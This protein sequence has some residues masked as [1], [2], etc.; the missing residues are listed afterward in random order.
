MFRPLFIIAIIIVTSN[1]Y[2]QTECNLSE[3]YPNI[4]KISKQIY[5]GE[6]YLNV[7]VISKLDTNTKFGKF[8]N[9]NYLYTDYLYKTFSDYSNYEKLKAINDSN[10][11][12]NVFLTDLLQ[13]T[14]FNAMMDK[15][16]A[17]ICNKPDF[18]PDT[19]TIN[20]LMN[21]AVKFF[22]LPKISEQ[23]NY[24]IQ[25]CVGINGIKNTLKKRRPQVEAFCFSSIFTHGNSGDFNIQKEFR[26]T[27]GKLYKLS[28]G[29]NL[30]ERLLRAQ[31]AV[32]MM[33]R[34]ND[35]LKNMLLSEYK[36]NM[37]YLPFVII[38]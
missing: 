27:V 20:E 19:I 31:G 18:I 6:E 23:G 38:D 15:F 25:I 7:F 1:L 9:E 29:N 37:N 35:V 3:L 32:Y 36:K 10:E 11:L 30:E 28:L 34:D 4:F 33:M 14:L 12:R 13:D 26:S 5:E 22:Y 21:I 17:R 2:S 16:L 8:I 24:H